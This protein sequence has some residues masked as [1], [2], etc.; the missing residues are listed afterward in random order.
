M[1]D[2]IRIKTTPGGDNKFLKVKIKQDFDFI[3]ILSLRISQ[4]QAYR[5]FCSDYGVVVGRVSVNNG[6]GIP[7]AR[8]SIFIPIDSDDAIDPEIL[9]LYPFEIITDKDSD[10]LPYNLLPKNSRGKDDCYTTIGTFPTKREIQDNPEISDIYCKYYKYTTTT[11]DSGDFMIFGVPV[12]AHYLHVDADISDIGIF[13]QK[14]YELINDGGNVKSFQSPTKYKDRVQTTNL[15]Q[16]KTFS[17]IS[18]TVIPFWGDTEQCEIGISRFDVDLRVT[19][20]PSALFVGSII[21]DTGKNSLGKTC[22]PS[23][24]MGKHS[25]LST[26][27]GTIEMIRKTRGG[28]TERFDVNG[29][30]V[31]D[32]NGTWAYLIPMNLNYVITSEEGKLIPSDDPTRGIPTTSNV[33]FRIGMDTNGSEGQSTTRA[34]YLVPNNPS[35][36]TID[37]NFDSSTNDS[38]FTE[39]IWN[40]IYTIKN[41]IARVQI[42]T[43]NPEERQFVGIKDVDEGPFTPFPFN[44]LD[45][46]INPLFGLICIFLNIFV[47]ILCV[48]NL[49][50]IPLINVVLV[51]INGVLTIICVIVAGITAIGCALGNIGNQTG[52]DEC[53]CNLCINSDDCVNG[54]CVNACYQPIL[55]YIPYITVTCDGDAYAPCG[56]KT[57]ILTGGYTL[58][59]SATQANSET[60][61]FH[62]PDDGHGHGIDAGWIDCVAI[63][64]ARSLNLFK[65]DFYNDWVNGTLYSY[66]LSVKIDGDNTKFCDT[67]CVDF[68][69]PG[70]PN[71]CI[72]T[73]IYDTCTRANPDPNVI[74]FDASGIGGATYTVTYKNIFEG[75]IKRHNG[76]FYYVPKS[77]ENGNKLY[78]TDIVSLGS[79]VDCHWK[80]IPNIHK[81]LTDTTYNV[82]PLVAQYSDTDTSIDITG[83]DTPINNNDGTTLIGDVVCTA[84]VSGILTDNDNCVNIRRLSELGVGLD[85]NREDEIPP[86]GP[87]NN[88]IDN[89]DVESPYIRGAF[90]FVNSSQGGIQFNEILFDNGNNFGH[91]NQ[92][93]YDGF[94]GYKTLNMIKERDNS[95]YFYFGLINGNSAITK[96]NKNF[97]TECTPE[98]DSDFIVIGDVISGDDG[99][100]NTTTPPTG[101]IEINILNGRPPYDIS[102]DGPT[103]GAGPYTNN[104]SMY[105]ANVQTQS[106]LYSGTYNVKVIDSLNRVAEGSFYVPGPDPNACDVQA[107]NVSQNGA[108]DGKVT[109]TIQNGI[110][111]YDVVLSQNGS[112]IATQI[113]LPLINNTASHVFPGL[114]SGTYNVTVTDSAVPS[115][116]CIRTVIISEPNVLNVTATGDTVSCF[117]EDDG[118]VT[119]IVNG[120]TVPY[121]IEWVDSV[122]NTVGTGMTINNLSLGTYTARVTDNNGS[123]TG[124]LLTST[125]TVTEPIDITYSVTSMN[126]GCKGSLTGQISV[127]NVNSENDVRVTLTRG[128]STNILTSQIVSNSNGT[129]LISTTLSPGVY[130]V[131]LED[132]GTGC[133]KISSVVISEPTNALSVNLIQ[134]STT[135]TT[136]ATGGWGDEPVNNPASNNEYIYTWQYKSVGVWLPV[137]QTPTNTYSNGIGTSVL[138]LTSTG[139][140]L[141]CVVKAQ[142]NTGSFCQQFTNIITV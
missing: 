63:G 19:I 96:M 103:I 17:P 114:G 10:G 118:R 39:L 107:T 121:V 133:I 92:N 142:N 80:G 91:D 81:Y 64:L 1:L 119:V 12:G 20:T 40:E 109:V 97:F 67:D 84:I 47:I 27:S 69:E 117:G 43:I 61:G 101:E 44:K 37:Y 6:L 34:K 86:L 115:S 33:R 108:L 54:D 138:N 60:Q 141:R 31:I 135:F 28:G 72:P 139:Y 56:V 15:S 110:P 111:P 30:Q 93:F 78:A 98:D 104:V 21:S 73:F 9:G 16:L 82:P 65:F 122:G 3:E 8:V 124:Q 18:A 32:D 57:D 131:K 45:I 128:V 42:S 88:K 76:Q 123:P 106:N 125:Y 130:T 7:N 102:W 105:A 70:N 62:Y 22:V 79:M 127:V 26:G 68:F 35:G 49:T 77:V 140:Q 2:N 132:T 129:G 50:I 120:G 52:E 53:K 100:S 11:N 134:N 71:K 4:S 29:G 24:K 113:N 112:Q 51:I 137:I 95:F 89:D 99:T 126:I 58:A 5:R 87:V 75:L 25:E 38:S 13:S 59:W 74:G 116:E 36:N 23:L 48:F 136:T 55:E 66:L 46:D 90:A 83:F 41:Y 94:R 85:E 14:P